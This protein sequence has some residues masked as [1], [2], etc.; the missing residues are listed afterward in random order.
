MAAS[1]KLEVEVLMARERELLANGGNYGSCFESYDAG[2]H[3]GK[4]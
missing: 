3:G 2:V 1:I 4:I